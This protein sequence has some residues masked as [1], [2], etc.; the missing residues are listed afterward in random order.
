MNDS[1]LLETSESQARTIV[2]SVSYSFARSCA[3]HSSNL[4]K[5]ICLIGD[6][7]VL[8]A[9]ISTK[10]EPSSIQHLGYNTA[11][12]AFSDASQ[13]PCTSWISLLV[14][15]P[16]HRGILLASSFGRV[17]LIFFPFPTR[18]LGSGSPHDTLTARTIK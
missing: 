16:N 6:T 11:A 2:E 18:A 14:T 8:A 5:L 17:F 3:S 7:F 10:Y 12:H 15:D 4:G 13:N 9:M 1:P